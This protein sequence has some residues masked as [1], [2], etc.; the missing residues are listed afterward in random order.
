VKVRDADIGA[1][2]GEM[3]W[4]QEE[5]LEV[6]EIAAWRQKLP[7]LRILMMLSE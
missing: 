6:E 3:K 5:E 7:I 4:Y 1:T 2:D